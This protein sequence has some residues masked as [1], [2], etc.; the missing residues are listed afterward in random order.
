MKRTIILSLFFFTATLLSAQCPQLVWADEFDGTALDLTKW[1]PQIGDGCDYGICG[2]GNNE[3]QY[4]KAENAVVSNGTLKIIAKSERVRNKAYTSARLRTKGLADFTFGRFEAR[5]KLLQGQGLWPA[6]WMLS[7]NEPYGGWPQSG[8]IDIMELIGQ[9]PETVHGTIHYGPPYPDNQFQGTGFDLYDGSTFADN[10]HVFAVEWEPGVIRWY[11]DDILYQTLTADD[12]A[13]NNWPFDASN[14]MH[15][16]LNVAVGGNWPGN[17]D[18]TTPFPSQMEVDYVRVYDTNFNPSI[19]G[20]RL[21]PYQAS[22]EV[23]TINNAPSNASFSWTVPAGATIVSGAGTSSITV[24]W[25]GTSGD[26]TCNVTTDCISKQYTIG[27]TVEPNYLYGLSFENFDDPANVTLNSSTGTLTEVS[28]PNSSGVN[29]SAISAEY[30]RNSQEQYD[31]ISYATSA[32]ADAS[33]YETRNKK[34]YMDV[35]TQAPAGTEIVIQLESSTA[36]SATNYPTGRHSRYV[37]TVTKN[38]EWERIAFDYLDSP[39]G[40]TADNAV[41]QIIILF[42]SNSFT[43]DTYYWDN[44]DSYTADDGSGGTNSPPTAS[45]TFTTTDLTASFDGSGSSDPDGSISSWAWDFGDGNSGSGQ[46]ASHTYAAAG[47]YTVSLTVT[48][49]EGATDTQSQ[50]VSVTTGTNNPPTASFTFTTTNLSADFDGSGSSDPDGSISSWAWDFGDGN[51]GSGATVS[52]TYATAGDY[53]VSLTVT[54]DSGATDTQSQIVSVTDGGTGDPTTMHVQSVVTGTA[55]AGQGNKNG[56]ATV[57]IHDNLE[58]VVA[59]ATVTGSFSGTF[60]ETVSGVTGADGTVTFTTSASAKGGV[61]VDFCVDDVTHATLTY[62]A[63]QNDITCTGASALLTPT[64][65]K[66]TG[67]FSEPGIFPNPVRSTFTLTQAVDHLRIMDLTG[68]II[69]ELSNPQYDVNVSALPQGTYL[70][71]MEQNEQTYSTLLIK[72]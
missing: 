49:N 62:D 9:H 44:F 50:T 45:F 13:P 40:S 5:I 56:T 28:N 15:F 31:V 16:L 60:S 37:G 21:V 48:D 70:V 2:W 58:N 54:D 27:V 32:I 10:F 61:T 53:T 33:Q 26:V 59:N 4:Y 64:T 11:V 18:E 42:A 51:S 3:L 23:Y 35:L 20:D 7:S 67:V 47:D 68:K 14:Q 29:T 41:D 65:R 57:T 12:V 71:R 8:E 34:F 39:D 1:E 55:N 72:Q 63:T 52:Y 38:G 6:F 36:A 30:I 43:G 24:D 69:M 19:S 25:G 22:G 66:E 46:T 17:P